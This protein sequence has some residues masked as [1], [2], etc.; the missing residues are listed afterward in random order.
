MAVYDRAEDLMSFLDKIKSGL[1]KAQHE[2]GDF[3]ETTKIKMEISKLQ[4]RKNELFGQI[5]QQIYALHAKGPVPAE[6]AATCT[7]IDALDAQIAAKTDQIAKINA[8]APPD[9]PKPAPG[10]PA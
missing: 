8:D 10:N 1:D 7:E 5:G 6:V 2:I 4:S 9:A 3:A